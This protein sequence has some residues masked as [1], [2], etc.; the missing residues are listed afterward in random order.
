M[1]LGPYGLDHWLDEEIARAHAR[2][3]LRSRPIERWFL[4]AM[5]LLCVGYLAYAACTQRKVPGPRNPSG[6]LPGSGAGQSLG[7]PAPREASWAQRGSLLRGGDPC[8]RTRE[9]ETRGVPA[10][11]WSEPE[12]RRGN[13]AV[14]NGVRVGGP[15]S[16]R[17]G[18]FLLRGES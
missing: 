18:A 12:G 16:L 5:L 9:S 1:T 4:G 10:A 2:R 17:A 8:D 13:C 6:R 11:R 3:V 15:A 14:P 7:R